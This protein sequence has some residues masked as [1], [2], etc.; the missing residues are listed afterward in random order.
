MS[1]PFPAPEKLSTWATATE[2][3]RQF[4]HGS[5][6]VV[7]GTG[8]LILG[9]SG[10]GKSTLAIGLMAHG[11]TLIS[12]DGVWLDDA[13]LRR[14][15]T[16]PALIEARCIGLLNAG[17]IC[18]HARLGLVIDLDRPEPDRLPPQRFVTTGAEKVTLILGGEQPS[19]A[20]AIL[21]RSEIF[22]EYPEQTRIEGEIQQLDPDHAVTEIWQVLT[23]QAKGRSD[24]KQITLFDSVG[25]AIEDFSALRYVRD[26]IEET[27]LFHP[28][29][30]LADPDDPR[31]LFGMLQR[32][33]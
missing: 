29:D 18:E 32:A 20:P 17:P 10:S 19:L 26:Q 1:A 24:D 33:K 21:H 7:A 31:D 6:V 30:L 22:V 2:G 12:D 4:F 9:A 11:A 13:V 28:L 25:F 15:D 16:A 14:P 27:G 8:V 3:T 23:G 5:A